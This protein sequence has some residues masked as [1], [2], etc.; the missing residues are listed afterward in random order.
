MTVHAYTSFSFSY[1]NR[2]RVLASSLKRQHPDWVVWAVLTDRTPEGFEF[3]ISQEHFDSVIYSEDLLGE[4][5]EAWLFRHDIV[6]ACTAVKGRALLHIM[7]QPGADKIF[8]FDPDIVVFG[9]MVPVVDLLDEWSI[10]LTPHQTT[11]ETTDMAIRDNEITSLHYGTYNLGFIALRNDAEAREFATWWTKRLDDWCYDRLDIGVF[12][13]QKWCNLIPCYFD[14]V[15]VLRDPG[16]NVASWNLSNRRINISSNGLILINGL[17]LRFFHFTK[18]GPL[19]NTMTERYAQDNLEVYEIWA[20]YEREVVRSTNPKIPK[21][22][23]LY[24]RFENGV[25]IPKS[26]RELYRHR[27]DLKKAFPEPRSVGKNSF[28]SWLVANSDLISN[29]T[30]HGFQQV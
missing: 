20:W 8:Y 5:A 4:G 23:W 30:E 10:V 12:V 25:T 7:D 29:A 13:D 11:P 22:W 28:Y 1:L 24:G 14:S 26:A 19:G 16:Y 2:A 9:S 6:E 3:D 18:L 21:G 27:E 17:P 15:K